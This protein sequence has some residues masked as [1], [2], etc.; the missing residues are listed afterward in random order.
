MSELKN[1]KKMLFS[2]VAL[3]I[4]AAIAAFA[5]HQTHDWNAPP[6][7]RDTPNPVSAD[8]SSL[9]AGKAIYQQHCVKC[10]G[11]TGDGNTRYSKWNTRPAD[12]TDSKRMSQMKDGELFW[13]ISEGK[14]PMPAFKDKLSEK[15]RWHVVNYIR[16]F[17][18][19]APLPRR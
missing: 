8:I 19:A 10:H 16:T 3:T 14:R 6:S 7:V 9:A 17:S 15:E 12:L 5:F 1:R 4:A 18:V 13:K 2:A 11:E